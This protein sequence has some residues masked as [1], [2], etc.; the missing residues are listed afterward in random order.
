MAGPAWLA[1]A[2][3]GQH[4]N[5]GANDGSDAKKRQVPRSQAAPKGL[6]SMFDV[7]DE[8]LDRLG[9]EQIRIHSPSKRVGRTGAL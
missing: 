5:A 4:E 1:A 8:L 9:L 6:A 7:A 3:P 2:V